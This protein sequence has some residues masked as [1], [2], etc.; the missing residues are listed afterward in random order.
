MRSQRQRRAW[1]TARGEAARARRCAGGGGESVPCGALLARGIGA[2][3]APAVERRRTGNVNT[4][5]VTEGRG[6]KRAAHGTPPPPPPRTGAESNERRMRKQRR[7]RVERRGRGDGARR[8]RCARRRHRAR[9]NYYLE[10]DPARGGNGTRCGSDGSI[11]AGIQ[12]V[13]ISVP[14]T[15]IPMCWRNVS[16][17]LASR[18]R[19]FSGHRVKRAEN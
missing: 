10:M 19:A 4:R 1:G 5:K 14:S 16:G 8:R 13:D 2:W 6:R 3:F 18:A 7:Q 9:A 11:L 15:K 12:R 17:S